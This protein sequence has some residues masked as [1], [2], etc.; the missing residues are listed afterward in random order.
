MVITLYLFL[1]GVRA[2]LVV[3]AT[4]PLSML[5]TFLLMPTWA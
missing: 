1:G 2:A 4:L 5:A 3:A